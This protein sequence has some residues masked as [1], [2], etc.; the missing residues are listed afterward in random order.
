[1]NN[2]KIDFLLL[3]A[4][5]L[6]GFSCLRTD[7]ATIPSNL[8][9][10]YFPN[11]VGIDIPAPRLS[12]NIQT[13]TR[14]WV[15]SA[16]H[17]QVASDSLKLTEDQADI[18]NSG[19]MKSSECLYIGYSGKPLASLGKY[20]WKVR[21]WDS[22]GN[23][24]D[25]SPIANWTMGMVNPGDWKGKWIASDL[26][27]SP[28]QKELKALPDFGMEPE[29]EMW[30]LN[31][32]IRKRT[33]SITSAPAV[34]LRK[35]FESAEPPVRAVANICGLGLN[36]LY[37]NGHKVSDEM[38]NPA[39]SDYQKRIFYQSFDVTGM[40][41]EGS[42][43]LGVILGNGWYN[44][45]IPHALR[46]YAADYIETPRMLMQVDLFY[47]D[48]SSK[49]VYSDESWKFTTD[50]PIRFNC[51]ISGETWDARKEMPGWNTSG[52]D[53]RA[54]K[55]AIP[56]DPPAGRLEAQM[57]HPVRVV[58]TLKAVRITP[59]ESGYSVDLEKEITGWCSIT[60]RGK[61]GQKVT[62]R[63][64]GMGS[65]TLGRYQTY[66]YIL[67]S[68]TAEAF[69]AR[70]SYNGIKTIEIHGLDYQPELSDI[71][72][73]AAITDF[74]R[75]G[76]FSCSNEVFNEMYGILEHT[77]R[78]YVVHIPN[79]PV[80]EKAGWTQD[81][82]NAF[83]ATA[84]SQDCRS[85]YVKWQ[86]D[87]LDIIHDN[88][89]VPPV[90]PG[91][92]DGPTINGP[93]WGGMIVYLPWRIYQYFGDR[94]ILEESYDAMKM[95]T[96]YLQ[97]IDSSGII[98]WG[99]GDWL[100][101]GSVRPVMTPVPFTST[102]GYYNTALITSKT[103]AI[104][105]YPE[106]SK[107]YAALAD[108]IKSAFNRHFFNPET[109][110][111]ALYSQ[112]SQLM[113]LVFNMVPEDKRQL[114]LDKLIRKIEQS[115][116]HAGTGFVA[117]PYLL[118]GLSDLG[119]GSLAYEIADQR[120]WPSWYD[121]VF[122]HGSPIFKEDWGGGMV[123]MPPLGGGLGWW[124]CYGLAGIRPDPEHPGFKHVII[125]PDMV[126]GLTRAS[127][128]YRSVYGIIRSTWERGPG[129]LIFD[130]EIPANTTASVYLPSS[131]PGKVLESGKPVRGRRE[132][133]EV[134]TENGQTMIRTGSGKYRFAIS[135]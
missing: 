128:E 82:E 34:Y 24:S 80:R 5:A 123:Q 100:E 43:T 29:S 19:K 33:D 104:L 63:F 12:W 1:M 108:E 60:V 76:S 38:L 55:Q 22:R 3:A 11:P 114:V 40:I 18:W 10:E 122:N 52:F 30:A 2:T 36:E 132:F 118:T 95:Y 83:D 119:H 73:I 66:E 67:N 37:I 129:G 127:G 68:A 81:A 74:P 21:V 46:Y 89:Y 28:L 23:R 96:G 91:R 86:H 116:N 107:K 49:T 121:M 134:K 51:L 109:G 54:W 75:A 113:P 48:G 72:G 25:W 106:E 131:D 64:P 65:H 78:N 69:N 90:T 99:L 7:P 84:Y 6:I 133:R 97:S 62:V 44:L 27:L 115:D 47:D 103:A 111:Y 101:P 32:Q 98:S 93:W 77:I 85:M 58:D 102:V 71:K 8:I 35:E 57:L 124:F 15:Q 56:A 53:D 20:W 31:E 79:D 45:V 117:T 130:I 14:G 110:E 126:S 61:A 17:I 41:S 87:F 70:F 4:I 42:N 9:C 112:A 13:E 88:G 59:I 92:F 39:P 50:G 135:N 94:K 125:R 16:Y 105:G 120:T 26:E